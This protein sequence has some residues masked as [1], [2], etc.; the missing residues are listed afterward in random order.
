MGRFGNLQ[1]GLWAAIVVDGNLADREISGA[2]SGEDAI[3]SAIR[4]RMGRL[5]RLAVRCT[6]GVLSANGPTDELIFCSRYGNLETLAALLRS[7]A[8]REPISPMGFS[9]SVHN[10]APG[11]VGQ[12]RNE[13]LSHTALAAGP[14]TFRAGLVESHARLATDECRDVTLI[15]ADAVLPEIYRDFEEENQPGIAMAL[16]L[17]LAAE[18]DSG[19][20][21]KPGRGGV[22][23]VLA[24][25]KKG[26]T[27]I[28]LDE[29]LWMGRAA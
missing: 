11:L 14:Q 6:L 26:T 27:Q 17:T 10:A 25:L 4:R 16:R 8:A 20:G 24:E 1:V 23:D 21:V 15:F 3:P 29:Y 12:I 5:E 18:S 22:M 9:G 7:L 28:A 2:A 13:R 19:I